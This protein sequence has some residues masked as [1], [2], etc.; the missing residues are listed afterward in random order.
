MALGSTQ[1]LTEMS[2]RNI[3]WGK[4]GRC[5][6]LTNLQPP[7][8]DC[9]EISGALNSWSL[10]GLSRPVLGLIYFFISPSK[11]TVPITVTIFYVCH[12]TYFFHVTDVEI[13]KQIH[14][15]R[16]QLAKSKF[17]SR[18]RSHGIES[19]LYYIVQSGTHLCY[20]K[21]WGNVG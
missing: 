8:A 2:T 3:S 4:G 5:V 15:W 17:H 6:G 12:T 7:C 19:R 16:L 10:K 18:V 13:N 20:R 21:N 14:S 9:L 1:P 11:V